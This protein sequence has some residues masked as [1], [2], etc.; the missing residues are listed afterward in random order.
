MRVALSRT[1]TDNNNGNP[2]WL[3]R[4]PPAGVLAFLRVAAAAANR[5]IST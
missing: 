5:G 2:N 3:K 4:P 1:P